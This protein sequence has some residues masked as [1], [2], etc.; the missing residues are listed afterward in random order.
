[1][2][3]RLMLNLR[4]PRL[5]QSA[6]PST[7]TTAE[8]CARSTQIV[9]TFVDPR[10]G[11]EFTDAGWSD[12]YYLTEITEEPVCVEGRGPSASC[13]FNFKLTLNIQFNDSIEDDIELMRTSP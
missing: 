6:Q 11:T 9:S 13:L 8:F 10:N 12:Q 1:M 5:T 3:T 7:L 2:I 4:D